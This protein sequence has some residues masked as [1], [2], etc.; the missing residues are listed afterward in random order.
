[1]ASAILTPSRIIALGTTTDIQPRSATARL[2][3]PLTGWMPSK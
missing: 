1:M 3:V 2:G